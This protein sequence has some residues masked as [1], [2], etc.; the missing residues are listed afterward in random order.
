MNLEEVMEELKARADKETKEKAKKYGIDSRNSLGISL[1]EL[2]ELSKKLERET[3]D[4]HSLAT[5]LWNTDVFE[6]RE[7]AAII[8]R[9]GK[10]TDDQMEEWVKD[11]DSWA[12]CDLVCQ[13]LFSRTDMAE[14]K[15]RE[16]TSREE[17]FVKRAGFA[18]LAKIALYRKDAPDK[19]FLSYFP[20]IERES[21][22]ERKYVKKAISW[23]LREIGKRNK[24]LNIQAIELAQRL[25]ERDSKASKWIASDVLRELQ[26]EKIQERL[27]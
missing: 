5:E 3:D 1:T 16:W 12:L 11:F 21:D 24:E 2:R 20:L 27:K 17:E 25:K 18:L 9:P 26:S 4:P 8:D 14:K 19:S 23:A 10:V 7:L 13:D 15:I 22:D 6:A